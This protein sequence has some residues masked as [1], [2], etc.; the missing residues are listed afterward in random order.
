MNKEDSL[1]FARYRK[2]YI[3]P[4]DNNNNNNNNDNDNFNNNNNDNFNNNNNDNDNVND[5]ENKKKTKIGYI[6]NIE[7]KKESLVK[8]I[9]DNKL[10]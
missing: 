1:R 7:V 10:I 3:P 8:N 2:D 6:N 5:N 4:V 9:I